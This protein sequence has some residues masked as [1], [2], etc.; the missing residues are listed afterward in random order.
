MSKAVFFQKG[1]NLDFT[2]NT[3]SVITAGDI[4]SLANKIAVAGGNIPVGATGAVISAGVFGILK[5]AGISFLA[6]D[7]VFFN[8][9]TGEATSD[10]SKTPAG[11]AVA[12]SND[13]ETSVL[14]DISAGAT[15]LA[16]ILSMEV[17]TETASGDDA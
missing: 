7:A 16:T 2:N 12:D 15:A 14:V 5:T 6:G 13:T 8:S 11:I 17:A 9:E 10:D 4:V 3:E 1:E